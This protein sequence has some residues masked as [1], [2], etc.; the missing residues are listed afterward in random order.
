MD[1]LSNKST[2]FSTF[3][4]ILILLKK[5]KYYFFSFSNFFTASFALLSSMVK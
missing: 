1:I 3:C 2:T 4:S 5:E